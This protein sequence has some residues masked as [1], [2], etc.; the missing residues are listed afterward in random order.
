M[1][2]WFKCDVTMSPTTAD[3]TVEELNSNAENGS[4]KDLQIYKFPCHTQT[5]ER[6]G[7][8]YCELTAPRKMNKRL[9]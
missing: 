7:R 3:D 1:I 8:N 4:I 2:D 9:D 6:H 5:V